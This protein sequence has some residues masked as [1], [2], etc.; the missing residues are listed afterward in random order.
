MMTWYQALRDALKS[1]FKGQ[2]S[3]GRVFW[4]GYFLPLVVYSMAAS[5]WGSAD[6]VGA[7]AALVIVSAFKIVMAVMMWCSA[8]NVSRRMWT[9]VGRLMAVALIVSVNNQLMY[10]W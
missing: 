5:E 10:G 2:L 8:T 1:A 6:A 4:A 3:L 9:H 7:M